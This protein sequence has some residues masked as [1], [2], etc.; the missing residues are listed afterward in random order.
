MELYKPWLVAP[1]RSRR[2]KSST[3]DDNN[4]NRQEIPITNTLQSPSGQANS[5]LPNKGMPHGVSRFE[6]LQKDVVK[7]AGDENARRNHEDVGMVKE[8][9]ASIHSFTKVTK[10]HG[11]RCSQY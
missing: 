2:K 1:T 9:I 11:T 10:V 8:T 4:R 7:G 6:V 5:N 3:R